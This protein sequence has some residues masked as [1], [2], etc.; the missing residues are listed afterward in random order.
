V[1]TELFEDRARHGAGR[2]RSLLT[3]LDELESE[4]AGR[5][6]WRT[7]SGASRIVQKLTYGSFGEGSCRWLI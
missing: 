1:A 3:L 2:Y 5:R 7:R 6:T 4:T